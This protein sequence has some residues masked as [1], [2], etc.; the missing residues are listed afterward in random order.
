MQSDIPKAAQLLGFP[1]INNKSH[2]KAFIFLPNSTHPTKIKTAK[3]MSTACNKKNKQAKLLYHNIRNNA[4]SVT[5]VESLLLK[6]PLFCTFVECA[7]AVMKTNSC[8]G[9]KNVDIMTGI[10]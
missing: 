8:R 7:E 1:A 3:N 5:V 2:I 6:R 10:G 9:V 4:V